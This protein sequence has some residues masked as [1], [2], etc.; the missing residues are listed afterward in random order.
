MLVQTLDDV[1][2][3]LG[4][5][6]AVLVEEDADSQAAALPDDLSG[7]ERTL[8]AELNAEPMSIDELVRRTEMSAAAVTSAMTMLAVRGI[9]EQRPGNVFA[10]RKR[11]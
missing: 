6:G 3:A 10:R 7:P 2:E 5:V 11:G 8:A 1:L 4:D 9:V